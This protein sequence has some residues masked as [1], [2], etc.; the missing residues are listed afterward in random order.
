MTHPSSWCL[1][2]VVCY[3]NLLICLI[4]KEVG[5]R[6]E[7]KRH[8]KSSFIW[9]SRFGVLVFL[10]AILLILMFA[11]HVHGAYLIN[12]WKHS[13]SFI[14]PIMKKSLAL[15]PTWP[16]LSLIVGRKHW[17]YTGV[18]TPSHFARAKQGLGPTGCQLQERSERR[19]DSRNTEWSKRQLTCE[20][21]TASCSLAADQ[22][23]AGVLRSTPS[24]PFAKYVSGSNARTH[25]HTYTP[26]GQQGQ[27]EGKRKRP[28]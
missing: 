19:W 17:E 22:G 9:G 5:C 26:W 12:Q 15:G 20:G 21:K 3:L 8:R 4:W 10:V 13:G 7:F 23:R 27:R 28:N 1:L 16:S 6:T 18:P 24:E 14:I 25:A 2:L 11:L